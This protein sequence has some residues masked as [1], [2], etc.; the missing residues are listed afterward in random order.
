M[1]A[2]WI[3]AGGILVFLEFVVP[4]MVLGFIGT[5]ALLIAL[6]IWLDWIDTWSG[7]LTCWF[8]LSIVLLVG[9]RGFFQRLVGGD[10]D[11]QSPD[12]DLDA[13]GTIVEVVETITAEKPGRIRYRD[14][15][16][17]A[18]CY[19]HTIEAGSKAMLAYR[20]NLVWVVESVQD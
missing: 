11:R 1:L 7:A 16:W 18:I 5:S 6:F 19:D 9:L 4:G 10:S 12:E 17:S 8:V 13:Y 20:D 14:A 2:T 3:I 15:T